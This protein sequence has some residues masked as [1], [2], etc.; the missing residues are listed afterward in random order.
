MSESFSDHALWMQ[1]CLTLARRAIGRTAPNPMVGCVVVKDG[2]VVGEGFHPKA[3]ESHAEVFALREA[4]DRAV[5][6]TLYVNLEPCNHYGRTPPCS[7]AV[8][9][10]QVARVVVGMVDPDP[11]VAGGGIARLRQA[12]IEVIVGVEEQACRDLNEAFVHRV[13]YHQPFGILKY[14]MTLDGK[15]AT[16]SGHSAWITSEAA[17]T[18][19]HHLRAQCGAVIVGTNTVNRDDPQLTSHQTD[20]TA[21]PNPIRV[22]MSRSLQLPRAAK[23]WQTQLVPTLVFTEQHPDTEIARHLSAQQVEVI[24]LPQVTPKDVLAVLH[25]RGVMKVLWECGGSLSAQAIAQGCVQKVLAFVAP[26]IVGGQSAPSPIG[27][28]GLNRMTE[29]LTLDRV[30][31]KTIDQDVLIS[32]YLKSSVGAGFPP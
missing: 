15:I 24:Y 21:I 2:I 16:T 10:A 5:G 19:V 29:A 1:R 11:R 17:R 6:A 20:N 14:A 31:L 18:Y 3:G 12:G 28:L 30:T 25:Q 4:G 23:L 27:E 32:G 26:K 7:E 8:V 9:K 22:V 13:T